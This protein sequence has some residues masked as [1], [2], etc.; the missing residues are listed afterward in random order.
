MWLMVGR[1]DVTAADPYADTHYAYN[2]KI[3]SIISHEYYNDQTYANDVGLVKT[4]KRMA[5]N[6]GVAPACMPTIYDT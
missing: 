5:W 1:D 3:A 4:V 6:R 2:Y